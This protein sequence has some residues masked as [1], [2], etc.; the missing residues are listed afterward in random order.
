MRI[1]ALP[2]EE[3]MLFHNYLDY[4]ITVYMTF[5]FELQSGSVIDSLWNLKLLIRLDHLHSF[6]GTVVA[7][8]ANGLPCA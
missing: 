5:P 2:S 7:W 3:R 4:E 6:S 1:V 8:T